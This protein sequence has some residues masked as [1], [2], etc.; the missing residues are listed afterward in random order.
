MFKSFKIYIK[1][2]SILQTHKV[3]F[4]KSDLHK[5]PNKQTNKQTFTSLLHKDDNMITKLNKFLFVEVKCWCTK[6]LKFKSLFFPQTPCRFLYFKHNPYYLRPHPKA[7]I[8]MHDIYCNKGV[9]Y[10]E[11]LICSSSHSSVRVEESSHDNALMH[12]CV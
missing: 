5:L 2:T 1:K 7:Y 9:F 4:N 11:W 10:Y 6:Q 3:Q 8:M 12:S